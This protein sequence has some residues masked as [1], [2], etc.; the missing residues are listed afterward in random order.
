MEIWQEN[1]G[2]KAPLEKT[3]R[4]GEIKANQ[5]ESS[6]RPFGCRPFGC[7][8]FRRRSPQT[9]LRAESPISFPDAIA[10]PPSKLQT[11]NQSRLSQIKPD[12]G[13][14][15]PSSF[16]APVARS[17]IPHPSSLILHPSSFGDA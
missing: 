16:T 17:F 3:G 1:C 4:P 8:V 10:L 13:P 2:A 15:H 12:C 14:E 6:L 11:P 9:R 7:Q 5:G